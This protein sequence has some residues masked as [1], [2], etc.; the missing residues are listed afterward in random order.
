MN[1]A[2]KDVT[3]GKRIGDY[4]DDPTR[5][6]NAGRQEPDA[7]PTQGRGH[8]EDPY[9]DPTHGRRTGSASDEDPTQGRTSGALP[10]EDPTQAR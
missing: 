3:Q 6:P 2:T 10:G 4:A 5:S 9:A 1:S 7:D 8:E